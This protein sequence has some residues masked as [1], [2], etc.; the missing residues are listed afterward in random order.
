M[1]AVPALF[2]LPALLALP[3]SPS[4]A[5]QCL[6]SSH[7]CFHIALYKMAEPS[8]YSTDDILQLIQNQEIHT[9]RHTN[10][11]KKHVFV[12]ECIKKQDQGPY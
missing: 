10:N 1:I 7:L 8:T 9:H 4:P 6:P 11:N 5:L 12:C 2:A 3:A